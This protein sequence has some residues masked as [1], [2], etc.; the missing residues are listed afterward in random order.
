VSRLSF[1]LEATAPA[2]AARAGRLTTRHGEVRTPVFMPVGTQA[3]VKGMAREELAEAGSQVLLANTYHLLLRPGPEVFRAVGGIHRFMRW[4][5]SVLTDSGGF[6]IFSLP[7]ARRM[8]EA[9]AAFR[10]YLDGRA[11]LLSPE[12][13]IETQ[14][15]I[16]SDLMMVLD[17]CVPSTSSRDVAA[18]AMERT[19]RWAAR[20]LAARGDAPN[21]LFAIVQGA[22]FE[23]LRRASAAAL[24]A[25]PFDGFAIGGLA[26]GETKDE[27]EHFCGLAAACLP[28]DKP[29]YLMGVGTPIDL[30]EAVHR[31]VD[32]FDCIIPSAYAQ[33]GTAFT[34][35]GIYRFRRGVYRTDEAPIDAA[36]ACRTCATY[37]RAYLHHLVKANEVLGWRLLTLHNLHFYHQLMATM[38]A[39]ICAGTFAALYGELRERLAAFDREK[40]SV[41][42]RRRRP[43][44]R[45]V[46]PVSALV[47]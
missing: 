41:P 10:S 3:T 4:D 7:N 13:S 21:A 26:V 32:M 39:A 28:A 2:T 12:T 6:Q 44:A 15:A 17:E 45:P 46:T 5:R 14:L 11:I 34:W 22:C 30:L 36:C 43:A 23:D 31:G 24:T 19:H 16:D 1:R 29:R 38:R 8:T 25:M 27:R 40:P 42:P 9:G 20:S 47:E 18:A 35:S 37:S 33:Q